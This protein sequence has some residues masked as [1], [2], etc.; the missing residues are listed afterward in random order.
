MIVSPR[1]ALAGFFF[2]CALTSAT[3]A[4]DLSAG[5]EK[6]AQCATCHGLDGIA[7]APD[8]PNIA[9]DSRYYLKDQLEAFRSGRRQHQQMSIIA[10]G[11]SDEDIA[12]LVAWY[13]AIEVT[14]TMPQ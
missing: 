13:S 14:A 8:A 4:A 7:T 9:G 2:A 5:R 12:D 10:Q 1:A 6:A 3:A 11:L